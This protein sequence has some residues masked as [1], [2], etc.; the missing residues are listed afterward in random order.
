MKIALIA[1]KP[2]ALTIPEV[3]VKWWD[4]K[5]NKIREA[6]LPERTIHVGAAEVAMITPVKEQLIEPVQEPT[7]SLPWWAWGLIGLNSIWIIS[8]GYWL[9]KKWNIRFSKPMFLKGVKSHLKSACKANDAKQ[10]EL[11]LLSWARETYP[12]IKIRSINEIKGFV[13]NEFQKAIDDLYQCL[14]GKKQSWKGDPLWQALKEFNV[15]S[16]KRKSKKGNQI[17]KNLYNP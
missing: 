1:S 14:Y 2:G 4:L 15:S 16:P 6:K 13:D 12:Q 11:Y 10:A 3:V 7:Q 17:L 5:Q 9:V 8:L